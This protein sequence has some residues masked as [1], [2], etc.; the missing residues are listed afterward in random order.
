MTWTLPSLCRYHRH[1]YRMADN[2]VDDDSYVRP[3]PARTSSG[4]RA[5]PHALTKPASTSQ[6]R[7]SRAAASSLSP[8]IMLYPPG[9]PV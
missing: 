2:N 5:E 9:I 3:W 4:N 8:F 6:L 7:A 1:N